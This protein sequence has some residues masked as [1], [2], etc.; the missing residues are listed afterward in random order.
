[1]SAGPG[2][3]Q[4]SSNRSPE[5]EGT[6]MNAAGFGTRLKHWFVAFS[7]EPGDVPEQASSRFV[8]AIVNLALVPAFLFY[9]IFYLAV[10]SVPAAQICM[11]ACIGQLLICLWYAK[12]RSFQ[13]ASRCSMALAVLALPS[14][15]LALGGFA[16]SGYVLTY[17]FVPLLL[18]STIENARGTRYWVLAS[19]GVVL[20][21]GIGEGFATTGNPMSPVVQ[22]LFTV[23]NLLGFCSFV[24][25]P[26]WL[27]AQRSQALQLQ[28]A[29][30][31]EAHLTRQAEHLVQIQEALERQ[32]ATADILKVIAGSPSDVQPVFE[33][34][35]ASSKRLMAGFST[36]VFR[37][38]EGQLQ[39]VSLTATNPQAD[40]L[41]TAMFPRPIAEFPPFAMVR[42]GQMARIEDTESDPGVPDLLRGIARERGYRAMLF[43]P[44]MRNGAVLGMIA[45]TREAPG[46]WEE[47]HVQLLHTFADQAVIAIENASMFNAL[48]TRNQEVTDALEQQQASAAVLNVVGQSVAD[49][50]PVFNAICVSMDRLWP[51]SELVITAL[52]GDGRL[53]YAAGSGQKTEALRSLFPRPAPG[54][55]LLTGVA[56]YWPDMQLGEDVPDSIRAASIAVGS[57][58][59]MLS[60]AMVSNGRTFGT[61]AALHLDMRPFS[62]KDARMIKTFADQAVIAIQNAQM[63]NETQEALA[64]QTASADILS[65]ISCS[66][67]DVQP[68]FD[69]IVQSAIRL[70]RCDSAFVLRCDG[71]T[72]SPAAGATPAG[73]IGDMGPAQL[74][75]EPALN[76]PSRAIV[77]RAVLNLPDWSVLDLPLHERG[78]RAQFGI[79]SALYLP[80]LR[81]EECIGLLAFASSRAHAFGTKEMAIAESFRDQA[82]IA[83]QNVRLFNETQEA[84]QQQTASADILRVISQSPDDVQPVFDAIANTAYRLLNCEHAAVLQRDGD[85]FMIMSVS[86]EGAAKGWTRS[87]KR[88][89]I[90]PQANYPSR[91]FTSGQLLHVP[92]W[93]SVERPVD[94][95]LQ[96]GRFGIRSSLMVPLLRAGECIGVLSVAR[97]TV[98]AFNDMEIASLRGF[99]DQAVIAIENVRLFEETR[100]ALERQT[101]M[102]DILRIIS[103]SPTDVTPV[104]QA[105]AE[106]ACVLSGADMGGA[107]R[108]DGELVHMLGWHGT[109]AQAEIVLRG[110]FPRRP[111]LSSVHGRS[112]LA[113][114]PVQIPDVLL[115]ADYGLGDAATATSYRSV[116]A[117]PMLQ[118]GRA[119]GSIAV[120]RLAAGAFP[121]KV[122]TLLQIFADQAVIA[123][124]NT[125]LFNELEA[126][127]RDVSE[128]LEQ[129]KAS[130]DI[131]SV[132]SSSVSDSQP[133][134][135]KILQSCQHLFGGDELDVLLV[136]E[137]GMLRIG[138][139]IGKARD[140]VAATFPA[141]VERT[142]AGQAIRER[143]VMHWPDLVHGA[144]VPGVLRKMAARIGYTS[145]MFAP[146]L[147]DGRGIGAIGVARSTG[148]FR[149]KELE[150]LQTFADQAVI[151]IQNAR[152]FNET[153][154]AL[155]QQTASADV[156]QVISQSVADN[157][158]VFAKI[159]SNA[160]R[161]LDTNFVNIGLI[162]EDG[163]VHLHVNSE[164]QFPDD[165]MYPKVIGWLQRTFPTTVRNTLHGYAAHK[166]MVL[167]Y[168]DILNGEG[169]PPGHRDATLWM[170]DHSE[171]FV[172]LVWKGQGIGSFAVARFP[173]RPFT[174]K[175]IALIKTFADQAVIAI[176]NAR[177]FRET[178][179]ARAA[180]ETAN[181]AKSS[182]LATMSHEIR[183]P[184]NAVIGMSGLLLDTP[185]NDEQRDFAGTIRDSG[186]ALL[187]II[188]D[189]LDFSKIEAGRMDVEAHPFDL[190]ECVESALDLIA[191]RAN[192]KKL[193]L[194]YV[195]EGDVPA[196]VDGDVTRLRQ[197]LLNLL[198][199][200][201]KFTESGEVVLTV[202]A[203]AAQTD[204]SG[205]GGKAQTAA[206]LEF[207]VRDS[208]IGLSAAGIGKLFQSFSQADSSTTRKYGGTGLGLAISK[209]LAE[210]MGGA[211]WVQSDG[212][213]TGSTFRFTIA[214]PV[215]ELQRIERRDYS[216]QQ[217][218]LVGKRL[219]VV[220]DNAT[221]R[222]I[223]SLQTGRWGMQVRDTES[224]LEA[225]R[226][227]EDGEMV[228]LAIVDMHMPEMDG[229]ALA[230]AIQGMQPN[231]P[232]VLFTSL[233]RREAAAEAEGLFE[234][235]LSKPLHQSQL[236]DCLMTQLAA[237]VG[238]IPAVTR[239][240]P[241]MDPGMAARHPLRILLAEDNVVNQKLA[242]RLLQHM[243]YRA[244]LASNGV[245]AVKSVER[246]DYDVVLMDVQ[247]PEMDGLE[248]SRQI[249]TRWP[250]GKRPWIVAMTANAMQ[251]D[252]ENCLAAGMDDYVTKPIRVDQL[253][254]ALSNANQRKEDQTHAGTDD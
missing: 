153:Q 47:H 11:G 39:L 58:G 80:L 214:A 113:G 16:S 244:D 56:S 60:A 249:T 189:I 251:G 110:S 70:I 193:E 209:R 142:P 37:I 22:R 166:R 137:N 78:I 111:D 170:G 104:F 61:I 3:S 129:Q 68:V 138:A 93:A 231:L 165:A 82:L 122:L 55:G 59:S 12:T 147:W 157:K 9:G 102:A 203:V 51:G 155:V 218:G 237:D 229:V 213:G 190:R 239:S 200:A 19:V 52:G 18:A 97:T 65:V 202:R 57:N 30:A 66:P 86:G 254:E 175:E 41:L 89:T 210:L 151:A 2:C 43:V 71:A 31:R 168:A 21:V 107:A 221:N 33:A 75:L 88:N 118:G 100:E 36:T 199:N 149:P 223:L 67:I 116:L 87:L 5:G 14:I 84:L 98:G 242:L 105:I 228:D 219:L 85:D 177:M 8:V 49:A 173:I 226:W 240:K 174:E 46:S 92:D 121:D 94:E 38:V 77:D 195:F 250:A 201:V 64:R 246:Q 208:G 186:D 224:P 192:E 158:P 44:L 69:A 207:A 76:F 42:D 45:V 241:I 176:Q 205:K 10:G 109:V 156:L 227:L 83:I 197:V 53:H 143:R 234:A 145:L 126:R 125:R 222:K 20:A 135:D 164:P 235:T 28:L 206:Q 106:R 161:I 26:Q 27:H 7:S 17:A 54:P 179:E 79:E 159:L 4:A 178:Q 185:L 182:F 1:M 131:L 95:N 140:I 120:G 194:A 6:P 132:I 123:V 215:A 204:E 154:E 48:Q 196:A 187:T 171:L 163:L 180:A 252:R 181:E 35:A 238:H 119:I 73:P 128:T 233:G 130:A 217:P 169:V 152:L 63:F 133:V 81:G 15:H 167:H 139:Y 148:P 96:Y 232:L 13:W 108:F 24:L 160:M 225:L 127:N 188:N 150:L 212:P 25:L 117:V 183:T 124:E 99:A 247:M 34:I 162:G 245:E 72:F 23:F 236:F 220:D 62:D 198:S 141:P 172:P 211:M 32:T 115:D 191:G 101:A 144:D 114:K 253:V 243:G 230:R 134:F 216:G 40:A 146:M 90:N 74:P 29:Q 103:E 50:Q 184:M 136:D 112:I 248:A 91:V